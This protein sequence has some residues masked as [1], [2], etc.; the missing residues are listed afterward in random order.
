MI[1]SHGFLWLEHAH[2]LII[3]SSSISAIVFYLYSPCLFVFTCERLNNEWMLPSVPTTAEKFLAIFCNNDYK[4]AAK[5]IVAL[6]KR[7]AFCRARTPYVCRMWNLCLLSASKVGTL[8]TEVSVSMWPCWIEQRKCSNGAFGYVS[9]SQPKQ[10]F[11]S[12]C[13]I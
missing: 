2:N 5:F 13:R 1:E 6:Q 7:R 10:M 4:S 12:R 9:S 3:L 11:P 8:V